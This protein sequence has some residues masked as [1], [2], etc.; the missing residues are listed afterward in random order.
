M[1]QAVWS[2]SRV[3]DNQLLKT[4]L[5]SARLSRRTPVCSPSH[6]KEL[7]II[8]AHKQ[9]LVMELLGV[10]LR[11]VMMFII[12]YFPRIL[13]VV[14]YYHRLLNTF[15]INQMMSFTFL[16]YPWLLCII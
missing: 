9:A 15:G 8:N 4:Y 2:V 11:L 5:K 10:L 12:L 1:S 3:N 7:F 14:S 16:Y 6:S 13:L